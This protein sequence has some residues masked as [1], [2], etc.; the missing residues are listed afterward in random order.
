MEFAE[1]LPKTN[2]KEEED[3]LD[4]CSTEEGVREM[5]KSRPL[6]KP[7]FVV[8]GSALKAFRNCLPPRSLCLVLDSEECLPLFLS[9]DDSS[10]VVAAGKKSTL[11]AARF[12]ADLRKIPCLL[13]PVSAALDGAFENFGEVRLE[14]K[15]ERVHLSEAKVGCDRSLMYPS[16]GLAYMRLL[17]SR[18]ALV[19]AKAMRRFGSSVGKEEAEERAF[20]ALL[21]LKAETLDFETVVRKNAVMRRLER[22]GMNAGEGVVLAAEIGIDGEE[23]AFFLL[24]ALYSAFFER[25]KPRLSVPDYAA[26]AKR[27]NVSY[28]AQK[29]PTVQEFAH[30]SALFERIRADAYREL[31]AFLS[32]IIHY[33]NNFFSLTGRAPAAA[34]QLSALKTLPEKSAGLSSVIRDFGLMEWDESAFSAGNL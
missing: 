8:D 31:N 12:F 10:F 19:E 3:E 14:N 17:L 33:E 7:L 23:Q 27:A 18:L 1:L 13:F 29:I 21:P 32:G 16:A 30:R 9:S 34:K 6:G 26:R 15:T 4:F 24:S 5:L 28:A 25:G 22:D 2:T 11:V 20:K